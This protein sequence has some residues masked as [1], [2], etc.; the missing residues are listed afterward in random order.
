MQIQ[1]FYRAL[2]VSQIPL[3]DAPISMRYQ[4]TI[5]IITLL[6]IA[7][8]KPRIIQQVRV[9]VRLRAIGQTHELHW[10]TGLRA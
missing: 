10:A 8:R 3:S 1:S 5:S 7:A 4:S 6:K 2:W 9:I